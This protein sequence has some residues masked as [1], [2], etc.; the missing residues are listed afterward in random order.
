MQKIKKH[1]I[2][3]AFVSNDSNF[4]TNAPKLHFVLLGAPKV[5]LQF[6]KANMLL[7]CILIMLSNNYLCLFCRT[8]PER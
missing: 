5:L 6:S 2:N 7:Y 1:R 3:S 4:N 8:S